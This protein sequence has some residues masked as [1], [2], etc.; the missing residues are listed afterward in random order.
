MLR[1]GFE[2]G[3]L[4]RMLAIA[5]A[6][7]VASRRVL[8]KIGLTFGDTS[9]TKAANRPATRSNRRIFKW[10]RRQHGADG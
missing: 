6:E 1:Y 5:D 2:R 8:E 9:S 7:N 10:F 4:T 3:G